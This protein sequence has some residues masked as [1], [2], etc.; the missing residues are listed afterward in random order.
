[1]QLELDSNDFVQRFAAAVV[2]LPKKARA[3]ITLALKASAISVAK[4][5]RVKLRSRADSSEGQPPSR[6]TGLLEKSIR[7]RVS[8]KGFTSYV[9]ASAYYS[10]FL[11]KGTAARF[12]GRRY[13]RG[14]V[15]ARP[16]L[17]PTLEEK[18][19]EISQQITS[20]LLRV[21]SEESA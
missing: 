9:N 15:K 14:V 19:P 7:T 13:A 4:A 2:R 5:T 1:M 20:A 11:E 16:F 17:T 10:L 3:E 21:L 6:K 12:T 18:S 8:K